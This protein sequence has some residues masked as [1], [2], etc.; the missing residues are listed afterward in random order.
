MGTGNP[1]RTTDLDFHQHKAGEQTLN[2]K[3]VPGVSGSGSHHIFALLQE[4]VGC[5]VV[6]LCRKWL[7]G[8]KTVSANGMKTP[9]NFFFF[10][11]V[12]EARNE[13]CV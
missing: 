11:P 6:Y 7:K 5:E 12:K 4:T 9:D 8:S 1:V 10:F 13:S 3:W 2:T